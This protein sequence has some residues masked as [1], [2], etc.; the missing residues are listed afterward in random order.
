MSAELELLGILQRHGVPFVIIG[1]HAVNFHGYG[2]VTEDIDVVWLR[3]PQSEEALLGALSEI[4]A[5]Y[6]GD[7][8]DP[9]TG[10]E[11]TYPVNAAFI[12]ASPLMMLWTPHGF[13][14]LFD[15]VPGLSSESPGALLAS[16]VEG[17]GYRYASLDHLRQMKQ[18]AGR[19]KD[20]LDLEN[21]SD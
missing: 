9:A 5:Q 18:A 4:G 20:R 14:D 21:L 12:H 8:I 3:S 1:G 19:T 13:L 16:S 11:R 7:D 6:I 2:R 17:G 10:I 15:Y